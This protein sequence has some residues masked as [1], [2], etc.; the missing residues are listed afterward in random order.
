MLHLPVMPKSEPPKP[1]SDVIEAVLGAIHV[2][3]D[4]A[5]GQAA[6]LRLLIPVL[7]VLT[8]GTPKTKEGALRWV[9]R[10]P[11]KALQEMAGELIEISSCT[12]RQFQRLFPSTPV[13]LKNQW[14]T[15]SGATARS[16]DESYHVSFSKILGSIVVA[17]ADESLVVTR[18]KVAAVTTQMIQ[19][20]NGLLGRL[21]KC[22]SRIE[23]GLS[24]PAEGSG[25]DNQ[26]L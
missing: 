15:S 21:T 13:L 6:T 22:R 12:L 17:V 26:R 16:Y 1:I 9:M 20:R 7:N 4:F 14:I 5:A 19:G 11:K 23:R 24:Q 10:H 25:R 8:T 3:S 2:D 18:N